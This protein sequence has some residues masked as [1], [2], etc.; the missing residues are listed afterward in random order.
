[1]GPKNGQKTTCYLSVAYP[2]CFKGYHLHT[3]REANYVI[4]RG[5]AKIILYTLEGKESNRDISLPIYR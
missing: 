2:G 3:V 1:M 5:K 4:V